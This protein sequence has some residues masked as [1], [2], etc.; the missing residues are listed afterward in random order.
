MR[1]MTAVL[2]RWNEFW[3]APA[4]PYPIAAF[5][6]ALGL[7]LTVYVGVLAPHVELLFSSSGVHAPYLLPD[8]APPAP[9]AIAFFAFWLLLC[10]LVTLG[11]RSRWVIPG[12]IA[13]FLY[14]Y[15]LSLAVRHSSFDRLI[16]IY[17]L[18]L[19]A[20]EADAA[21]AVSAPPPAERR[22]SCFAGRLLRFQTI[23]L[24]L[25]TGQWKLINPAWHSGELLHSTLQG[26]WATPLGFWLVRRNFPA[27]A[28]TVASWTVIGFEFALGLLLWMRPTRALGITLGLLFHVLNSVIIAIPE[29]LVCIAPYVFFV[30]ESTVERVGTRILAVVSTRTRATSA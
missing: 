22:T 2:C 23:V 12:L 24:Y 29:F 28:W 30:R 4:S 25:G 27:E 16:V 1:W 17:L 20:S 19:W 15:F 6:I 8:Y 18:V 7:Y 13:A 10:V 11:F 21:W 9:V 3:F 14:H 5:R 26:V